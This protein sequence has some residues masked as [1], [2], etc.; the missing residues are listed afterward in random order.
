MA[1][2]RS[3][4]KA[5]SALPADLADLVRQTGAQKFAVIRHIPR[6]AYHPSAGD[7]VCESGA[8]TVNRFVAYVYDFA[9][10]RPLT[11]EERDAAQ[12]KHDAAARQIEARKAN[13]RRRMRAINQ[14]GY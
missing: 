9:N 3:T 8:V 5:L 1:A 7:L 4:P 12:A 6:A 13:H 11:D 14:R 10:Y 2:T